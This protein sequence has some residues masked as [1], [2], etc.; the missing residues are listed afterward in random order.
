LTSRKILTWLLKASF[1]QNTLIKKN[2]NYLGKILIYKNIVTAIISLLSI[3]SLRSPLRWLHCIV[4][5]WSTPCT[6]KDS[7]LKMLEKA[8]S[9]TFS[10]VEFL[11]DNSLSSFINI[12]FT[13]SI[14]SANLA[15]SSSFHL[16]N[17]CRIS[18][19]FDFCCSHS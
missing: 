5:I 15:F 8:K 13:F 12:S 1:I 10:N 9:L 4:N 17:D 14:S 3:S 19:S 18:S 6:V 16:W 7:R 2:S 11:E